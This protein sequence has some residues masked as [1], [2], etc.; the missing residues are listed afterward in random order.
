MPIPRAISALLCRLNL[1]RPAG[2]S[3][4]NRGY[5]FSRCGGCGVDLVRT[6]AG[7]WHVPRGRKVVW[8]PRPPRGRKDRE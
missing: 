4:W 7:K 6:A 2:E 3:V 8:K 1:H 5:H